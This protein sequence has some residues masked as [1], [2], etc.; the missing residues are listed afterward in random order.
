MLLYFLKMRS[1]SFVEKNKEYEQWNG[2][3]IGPSM[4]KTVFEFNHAYDISK[5]EEKIKIFIRSSQEVYLDFSDSDNF[6]YLNNFIVS[7]LT[8]GKN[9]KLECVYDANLLIS[10]YRQIKSSNEIKIIKKSCEIASLAHI[11]AMKKC[12]PG[13]NEFDL[14]NEICYTFGN[15]NARYNSYSPIVASGKNACILHYTSNNDVIKNNSIILIDAG[16]EYQM[17]ASDITRSFPANGKFTSFQKDIY[18]LV[19]R[20]QSKALDKMKIG[21][22]IS[23]FH[24]TAVKVICDGLRDLKIINKSSDEI[25]EKKLYLKYYMHGTGHFLGLD[26]HDVGIYTINDKP[27]RLKK[28]MVITLEPG[29][30]IDKKKSRI[31]IE[32]DILIDNNGPVVLT[33]GAPKSISQVEEVCS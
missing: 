24:D 9:R 1:I 22:F 13:L 4:A 3:L 12:K 21:N 11:A 2:K 29:L 31:R 7:N 5:L 19:L 23:E 26:V 8:N 10:Q 30:Y 14:E 6:K 18:S 17:Y 28:G 25:L 33:K 15:H 16:C 20:A 27:I 32:D